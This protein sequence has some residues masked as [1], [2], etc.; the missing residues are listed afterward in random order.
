M[1]IAAFCAAKCP[2][3]CGG[4]SNLWPG[5]PACC[6]HVSA[7]EPRCAHSP[8]AQKCAHSQTQKQNR[9]Q[10]RTHIHARAHARTH[11]YTRTHARTYIRPH[12]KQQ[13]CTF[14]YT[15]THSTHTLATPAAAPFATT[16]PAKDAGSTLGMAESCMSSWRASWRSCWGRHPASPRRSTRAG[17]GTRQ[18]AARA[19][20][21]GQRAPPLFCQLQLR[22]FCLAVV[23]FKKTGT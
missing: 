15:G 4:A 5:L 17:R 3:C 7:R 20:A 18:D 1:R 12:A 2:C 9:V 11:T 13:T 14:T 23:L 8:V 22:V 21:R 10:A 19:R 16:L 6:P